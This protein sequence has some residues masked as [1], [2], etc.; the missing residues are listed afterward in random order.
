MKIAVIG[1]GLIGVS[2]AYFLRRDGHEV[3]VIDRAEGP[4]R[5]TSFA[6]GGLLTPSMA[7]PWNAPGCW[8]VLLASL[9]RSDSALQLRV[10][11]LPSMLGWGVKFLL[12]SQ[13]ARFHRNTLNN[14]RLALHSLRVMESL[15]QQVSFEYGRSTAGSIKLYRNP[16]SLDAAE[17]A[18]SRIV[19]EGLHVRR[20]SVPETLALEPSL[21]PIERDLAGALHFPS[22]ESGDAHRFCASLAN[23][24]R[25]LGVEFRYGT[26][27]SSIDVRSGAV[28]ALVTDRER[29]VADRYVVAAGSYSPL[30]LQRAG[31]DLPVCPA[32]GYS[33]T[34]DAGSLTP[35][36]RVALVDDDWHAALVPLDGALRVAGTAEFAGYD[37]KP[38]AGRT[39]NLIKLVREIFPQAQ[40]DPA[41]ARPWCGLRPMSVDG[42]PI[43]GPT[44]ISN[45]MVNTGHGHLGWTMAAGS[46][47]LL[48]DLMSSKAP[49]IEPAPF[50]L[51]R[52]G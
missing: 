18:A 10:R 19:P 51:S 23:S 5:E 8:R 6:N 24:A 29:V 41:A 2:T 14:L 48:A 42:V 40:F 39:R 3:T 49:S 27:I 9:T 30:L 38:N 21:A 15:R 47:Q 34:F 50:A 11:A 13:E 25:E 7:D 52:F 26:S 46:G 4:G 22:D 17:E 43:I 37:T 45:L 44:A 16:A 31:V 33:I 36:P 35:M 20:L 12:N 28:A 32:K 1:A